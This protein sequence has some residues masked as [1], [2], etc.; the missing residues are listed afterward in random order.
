MAIVGLGGG[1]KP[2]SI[3]PQAIHAM[4]AGQA[5]DCAPMASYGLPARLA[6][7][8]GAPQAGPPRVASEARG[9]I[10]QMCTANPLWG[11]PRIHGELLKLGIEVS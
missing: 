5:D 11:A 8:V 2:R 4:G 10:G 9:L 6:V 1:I 3:W 7:P